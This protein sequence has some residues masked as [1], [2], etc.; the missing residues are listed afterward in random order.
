VPG[1]AENVFEFEEKGVGV[2]DHVHSLLV[3]I[4]DWLD[5]TPAHLFDDLHRFDDKPILEAASRALKYSRA[6]D[7]DSYD[8]IGFRYCVA[9][10]IRGLI[11]LQTIA[12]MRM[13]RDAESRKTGSHEF[14]E[15]TDQQSKLQHRPL[16]L[17]DGDHRW[18]YLVRPKM[19]DFIRD[20]VAGGQDVWTFSLTTPPRALLELG[21]EDRD[22]PLLFTQQGL[23]D[24]P[25]FWLPLGR[26]I[27]DGEFR[28]MQDCQHLLKTTTEPGHFY[29][30]VSH[31][32]LSKAN[33]DPNQ[34]HARFLAWQ[35]VSHLCEAVRIARVRGLNVPRKF[36]REFGFSVGISGSDLAESLLVN[37]VRFALDDALLEAASS[38]LLSIEELIADYGS[39]VS[40]EPDAM[41]I[42]RN[43]LASAPVIAGLVNRV[44]LWYDYSCMP[45]HPRTD[46]EDDIFAQALHTLNAMQILGQT[47]ILFD[48]VENYFSRAWC[49]LE[50]IVADGQQSIHTMVGSQRDTARSGLTESYF[51]DALEDRPHIVWRALL[52]TEVFKIQTPIKCMRR[53]GL[54]ATDPIDLPMLYERFRTKMAPMKIHIDDTEILTGVVPLPTTE[55]GQSIYWA[56]RADRVVKP[57]QRNLHRRQTLDWTAALSLTSAS[58][59]GRVIDTTFPPFFPCNRLDATHCHVAIVGS[60][61]AESILLSNWVRD[62][63][64]EL[65]QVTKVPVG[66]ISWLAIDIAPVGHFAHASLQ[67]HAVHA[68][69]WVVLGMQMRL[70]NG[71]ITPFLIDL[72]LK[73]RRTVFGLEIDNPTSNVISY[74]A[75]I[76][77]AEDDN[78]RVLALSEIDF[79]EHP[80]GMYR[81]LIMEYLLAATHGP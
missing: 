38:E 49:T 59:S 73:A 62:H 39:R 27:D 9:T 6:G 80:G 70:S 42:L 18:R 4:G 15:L 13:E 63:Q 58:E 37:V 1:G 77:D 7:N 5:V 14:E 22:A 81:A 57:N 45:Q 31:R 24:I 68:D 44:L 11:R 50:A 76:Q 53:L 71:R 74:E 69:V 32:W 51:R 46:A 12:G 19:I 60:C 75:A 29:G 35:M 16:D 21:V 55:N 65:E 41:E 36:N 28:R 17:P 30:F 56:K 3:E 10:P 78:Q 66:S 72:L 47:I 61:E 8:D 2:K 23:V 67:A 79:P 43:T 54:D 40:R 33:P 25:Q 48:D 20:T 64:E 34:T 26:L 52:D